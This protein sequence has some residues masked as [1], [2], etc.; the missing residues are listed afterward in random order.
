MRRFLG[1]S[2]AAIL[3]G[4][5]FAACPGGGNNNNTVDAGPDAN[6]MVE[7]PPVITVSGTAEVHPTAVAY[8]TGAGLTVPQVT[9]LTLQVE[10]PLL[11]LNMDPDAGFGAVVLDQSGAFS[12]STVDTALVSLGIAAAI[13]VAQD[14]GT[15]AAVPSSTL[16]FD[17][18]VAQ[19]L[20]KTDLNDQRAYVLPV[21]FHDQLTMLVTPG[22]IA[23]IT[24]PSQ[25]TLL[26]AGFVLGRVVDGQG[27]PVSGKAVEVTSSG[28]DVSNRVFYV[29]DDFASVNQT[30]TSANGL[31]LFV[32]NGAQSE[33]LLID[34][35]VAQDGMY[36]THRAGTI[37]GEPM[38]ITVAP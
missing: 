24:N 22:T 5:V 4:A 18:Q 9:G 14:A 3:F 27:M 23:G 34:V 13:D 21:A 32:G 30:G 31:F 29:A 12:V 20:P 38:I 35:E 16:L 19:A 8:M 25:T 6:D 11:A 36:A 33:P 26:G 17:T 10:E 1:W 7:P 15:P 2:G 37:S 28:S